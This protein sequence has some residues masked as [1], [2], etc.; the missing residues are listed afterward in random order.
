MRAAEG[1]EFAVAGLQ[2]FHGAQVD[3]FC[4]PR[5]GVVDEARYG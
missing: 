5:S 1:F 3:L 4:K 2:Q